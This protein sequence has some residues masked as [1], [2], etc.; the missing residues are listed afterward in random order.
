MNERMNE[1]MSA[2]NNAVMQLCIHAIVQEYD[3]E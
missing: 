1:R 3:N 2:C